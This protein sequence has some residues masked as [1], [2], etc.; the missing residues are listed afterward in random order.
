MKDLELKFLLLVSNYL[1]WREQ[2]LEALKITYKFIEIDKPEEKETY[3][4]MLKKVEEKYN[5][6]IEEY[7]KD[8]KKILPYEAEYDNL[9][10][11]K[12][13]IAKITRNNKNE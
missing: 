12:K 5:E 11:A 8:F 7:I 10:G 4:E 6:I 3:D 1:Q 9:E 2:A 13:Y